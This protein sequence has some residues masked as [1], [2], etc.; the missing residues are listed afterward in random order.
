MQL[1]D[2]H[3]GHLPLLISIPHAGTFVPEEI[4][5]RFTA[6]ARRLPDTDWCVHDLYDL[7]RGF[8]ASIIKANYSRYVVDVNRS[9]D[10]SSLY[11]SHPTTPVCA[12][13][14]F[15]GEPIYM[16]G[17]EPSDAEIGARIEQYW[18]PYHVKIAAELERIRA[19]QG[20]ALLWDA[21]SILSEIPDLFIGVLP[22]FNFGTRDDQSCPRAVA[23]S[24]LELVTTD[25]KF[26]AVLNGRFRGGYITSH[27][28]RPADRI[29][30]VQLELAQR[31][32]MDESVPGGWDPQHAQSAVSMI[33]RL[34]ARYVECASAPERHA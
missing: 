26:G 6:A 33:R 32:Y 11:A 13:R 27:Y 25:G 17:S 24:L 4:G 31:A 18:R 21:H 16:S 1:F 29:Y 2:F 3:R 19:G 14:T 34:L 5:E 20:I 15:A 28:G 7:A 10:S 8:G 23:D 12:T 22:E 30:A 9:V